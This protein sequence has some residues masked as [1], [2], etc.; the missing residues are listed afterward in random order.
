MGG[1]DGQH[2]PVTSPE[3]AR[4]TEPRGVTVATL[5]LRLGARFGSGAGERERERAREARERAAAGA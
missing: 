3:S 2:R 4:V 1:T 5:K